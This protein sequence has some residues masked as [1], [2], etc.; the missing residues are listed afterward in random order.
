MLFLL[1]FQ[2][3]LLMPDAF[4]D[5][6]VDDIVG[7]VDVFVVSVTDCDVQ[8]MMMM[9]MM[10]ICSQGSIGRILVS[11]LCVQSMYG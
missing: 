10:V 9:M 5:A 8:M 11:V 4:L 3:T 1:Q 6:I 7:V 2:L